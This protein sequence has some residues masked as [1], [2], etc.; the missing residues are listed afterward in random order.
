MKGS[1]EPWGSSTQNE[2]G[3]LTTKCKRWQSGRFV[4]PVRASKVVGKG[5]DNVIASY[6]LRLVCIWHL[7]MAFIP[8]PSV[9][10]VVCWWKNS[11]VAP[12]HASVHRAR[13]DVLCDGL[14]SHRVGN[15]FPIEIFRQR[16]SCSSAGL[17]VHGV[18]TETNSSGVG[19]EV[20]DEGRPIYGRSLR[21]TI[22]RR[23]GRPP[24][25]RKSHCALRLSA[26]DGPIP[27]L[28]SCSAVP[29]SMP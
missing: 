1:E 14:T 6:S 17:L 16:A 2:E 29:L 13:G 5:A 3:A 28:P 26:L 12:F 27:A 21:G 9:S 15:S 10:A 7:L 8:F 4:L 23:V 25:L 11:F 24:F 19:E 18:F 20:L 22:S